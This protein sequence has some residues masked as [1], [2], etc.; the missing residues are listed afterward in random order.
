MKLRI[1]IPR[2]I[3]DGENRIATTPHCVRAL[4]DA[5]AKVFVQ[6]GA[7]TESGFPDSAFVGAGA[8]IVSGAAEAWSTDLVVKVK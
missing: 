1:G 8:T 7:G 6:K 2:E 4:R 3:K 5:G